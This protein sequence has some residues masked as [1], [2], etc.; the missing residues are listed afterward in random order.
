MFQSAATAVEEMPVDDAVPVAASIDPFIFQ[1]A[2][3]LAAR[4]TSDQ[5]AAES[6][7]A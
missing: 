1:C 2:G 6:E 7:S 4:A 5:S 3:S